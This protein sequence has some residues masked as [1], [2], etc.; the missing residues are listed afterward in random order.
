MAND[1]DN[2]KNILNHLK[3]DPM[4]IGY[5]EHYL[6][7]IEKRNIPET[8]V[9]DLLENEIPNKITK[10]NDHRFEL[11]YLLKD[12]AELKVIITHFNL[13]N[14]IL[15]S[16][17]YK[18]SSLNTPANSRVELE[19]IYDSAFDLIHIY[20]KAHYRYGQT[21]EIEAGFNIDFDS[22]GHPIAVE[23]IMASKKFKLQ[24]RQMS[25][26]SIEGQIEITSEIIKIR[27]E[28]SPGS[29][30]NTRVLEREVAN[31][32]MISENVFDLIVYPKPNK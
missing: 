1:I 9:T 15:I 29:D 32:Y 22:C 8:C 25:S 30:I 26:A 24:N 23:M 19:G 10:I 2:V 17:S 31:E 27:L 3:E 6:E 28:A 12:S 16:A 11:Q 18:N 20:S 21:V 4:R 14:I 7:Q 5:T 13:K